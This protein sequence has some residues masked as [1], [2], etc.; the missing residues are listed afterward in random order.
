MKKSYEHY[1]M[2]LHVD[3]DPET[4]KAVKTLL[5][6]EGFN[7]ET[8]GNGTEALKKVTKKKYDLVLLD[9]MMPTLSGW[10]V[11]ERIR[12]MK[13]QPKVIFLTVLEVSKERL[14]TLKNAGIAD[15]ITKPFDNEDFIRR[16][17]KA[18]EG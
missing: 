8:A 12:K 16:I 9:V 5:V 3:D 4:L 2:L 15:Y 13:Q 18:L 6:K 1:K 14:E 7:V 11:F 17:K 10:D